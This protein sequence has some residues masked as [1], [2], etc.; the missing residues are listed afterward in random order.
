MCEKSSSKAGDEAVRV[1]GQ[2]AWARRAD[3]LVNGVELY[4]TIIEDLRPWA[5]KLGVELPTVGA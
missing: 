5:D 2:R 1:P 3:Q 4:P